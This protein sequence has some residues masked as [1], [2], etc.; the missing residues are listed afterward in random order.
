MCSAALRPSVRRSALAGRLLCTV[1]S[2][3]AGASVARP[4][5]DPAWWATATP[6]ATT[7]LIART[8][9]A[10]A[11]T[12]AAPAVVR[13][14]A[15][16]A[17]DRVTARARARRAAAW[18]ARHVAP[19]RS[20][21]ART[22]AG[23][24]LVT[25][26]VPA[27]A[28]VS[29]P[30]VG[31][32][33]VPASGVP[34]LPPGVRPPTARRPEPPPARPAPPPPGVR[35]PIAPEPQPPPA[36]PAPPTDPSEPAPAA[37]PDPAQAERVH[38]AGRDAATWYRVVPGDSLW[39]IA[40]ERA[41]ADA[42]PAEVARTWRRVVA[43]NRSRLRSGHPDLVFPGERLLLPAAAVADGCGGSVRASD[44]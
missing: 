29:P 37:A 11:G 28:A 38:R 16:P 2:L 36:R 8:V 20:W 21:V 35:P 6:T 22:V 13:A 31:V 3:I 26:A 15:G 1:A 7:L 23:T 39:S 32:P 10:V 18:G 27:A 44:R 34:P 40:A 25:A 14:T 42:G 5:L 9:L 30:P 41:G 12:M 33:S 43:A 24:S 4:L 19:L 17:V